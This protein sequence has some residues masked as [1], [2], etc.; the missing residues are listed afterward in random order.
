MDGVLPEE[1]AGLL[2]Q[3]EV[4]VPPISYLR[5]VQR[6]GC[7]ARIERSRAPATFIHIISLRGSSNCG[8]IGHSTMMNQRIL[9]SNSPAYLLKEKFSDRFILT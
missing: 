2:L 9:R 5:S 8:C 4:W 1:D 6:A 7:E 3:A